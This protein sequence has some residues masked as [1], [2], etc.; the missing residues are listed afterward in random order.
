VGVTQA[1][2]ALGATAIPSRRPARVWLRWVLQLLLLVLVAWTVSHLDIPGTVLRQL[3]R[4]RWEWLGAALVAQ[5]VCFAFTGIMYRHGFRAVGVVAGARRLLGVLFAAIFVKT[6]VPLTGATAMVVFI[7]DAAATGQSGAGA[8][9]ATVVVTTLDLLIVVP[10]V[11]AGAI[12]LDVHGQLAPYDVAGVVLYLGFVVALIVGLVIAGTRPAFMQTLLQGL[13]WL[14]NRAGRLVRR[15][16]LVS[17]AWAERN[18]AQFT[19]AARAVPRHRRQVGTAAAASVLSHAANGVSLYFL[20][21]ALGWTPSLGVVLAGLATSTVFVVVAIVPDG[22]GAVEGAM[23]L[24]FI[25]L[26]VTPA[27]AIL[28]TLAYRVLNVWVPVA[29]GFFVVRR[30]RLFGGSVTA[31][32]RSA[33]PEL[34]AAA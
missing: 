23:A 5:A 28:V 7:D 8:A 9:A 14:V 26:G 16:Q 20:F 4:P 11:I 30:L 12:A 17:P 29:V 22:I 18:A 6:V 25:S 33:A 21:L 1:E 15:P 19:A 13:R 32:G 31:P 27:I 10:V 3:P 2:V 34:P 24:A